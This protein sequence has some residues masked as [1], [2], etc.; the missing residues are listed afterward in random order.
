ML[1]ELLTTP[2]LL[3]TG[4]DFK[5][6]NFTPARIT[7]TASEV[8]HG[9]RRLMI[10]C[11]LQVMLQGPHITDFGLVDKDGN[12]FRIH[13]GYLDATYKLNR[14]SHQLS[15]LSP[16]QIARFYSGWICVRKTR[17]EQYLGPEGGFHI[18]WGYGVPSNELGII[19]E[20]WDPRTCQ[21]LCYVSPIHESRR[22]GLCTG[23][24]F[25]INGSVILAFESKAGTTSSGWDMVSKSRA[26]AKIWTKRFL[27]RICSFLTV[28]LTYESEPE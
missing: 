6:T 28:E 25:G 15:T 18:I 13:G 11:P 10:K 27:D 23:G 14:S 4:T 20:E 2:R 17:S 5:V 19:D 9:P 16:K 26:T 21:M 3:V 1:S 8:K 24:E 7:I 12:P 22:G